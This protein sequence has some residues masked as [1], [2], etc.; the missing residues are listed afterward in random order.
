MLLAS[1][2]RGLGFDSPICHDEPKKM[3]ITLNDCTLSDAIRELQFQQKKYPQAV[4]KGKGNG[5]VVI[6]TFNGNEFV[7]IK[8]QIGGNKHGHS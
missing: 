1:S 7:L 2:T 6:E 3:Q 8:Q 4:F 5:E